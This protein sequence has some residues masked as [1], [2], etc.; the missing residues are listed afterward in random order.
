MASR[1]IELWENLKESNRVLII[2]LFLSVVLNIA[3]LNGI[4]Y[5]ATHKEVVI[6]MPPSGRLSVGG[7]GY[8]IMWARFFVDVYGN[9]TPE[10]VQ[11][12][13]NILLSYVEDPSKKEELLK[14]MEDIKKNRI[15][16]VLIPYEGTWKVDYK[17]KAVTVEGRLKRW[18]GSELVQD[19]MVKVKVYFRILGERVMFKGVEYV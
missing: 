17:A 9:F 3:M 4:L 18:I 16:Q 19:R 10:T 2:I 6:S 11:E 15:T 14:E 7:Q 12:R 1:Y 5:L 13:T 8:V